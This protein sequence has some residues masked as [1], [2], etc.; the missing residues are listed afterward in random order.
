VA[1]ARGGSGHCPAR[2][3]ASHPAEHLAKDQ[4]RAGI[5]AAEQGREE[6]IDQGAVDQPVDV[7]QAVLED[8]DASSDRKQGNDKPGP[9]GP[10]TGKDRTGDEEK[11]DQRTGIEEPLE[12]LALL[13]LCPSKAQDQREERGERCQD[14][15][16]VV[17]DAQRRDSS[18]PV[19]NSSR[20]NST[21][22]PNHG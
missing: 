20:V 5:D 18:R 22:R 8:G 9:Q 11:D 1:T 13:T 4:H 21:V 3:V 12:L 15:Q 16:A 10:F 2:R 17:K 7:V 14:E 19:G 6:P